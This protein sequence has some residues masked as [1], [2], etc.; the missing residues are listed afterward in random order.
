[1][2][3]HLTEGWYQNVLLLLVPLTD[4]FNS[5]AEDSSVMAMLHSGK[6][7]LGIPKI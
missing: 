4:S 3:Y 7:R 2:V 6:E 1:M 5:L